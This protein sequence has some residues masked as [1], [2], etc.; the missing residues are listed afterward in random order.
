MAMLETYFPTGIVTGN[1]FCNR[2]K[3]REYL[4]RR[5]EQNA[6]IVL[7][8]P[9][10]YGKSSLVAQFT[11]DQN[12]PF[13]SVD[14]LP[15]TS[16][17]YVKNAI[18]DGVTQ[19]LDAI[20]PRLKNSKQKLLS[21][22]SRMNPVIELSAFG[23]KI[24]LNPDEK[25]HA[26]TIM[27]LLMSL[28]EAAKSLNQRLIFVIDEFQQIATLE[29]SHS[30]EASIRHAVERSK[31]V[32][33]IFAG[34]N[35]TLLE[36][37]FKNKDRPLYH[38]CDEMKLHRI[39]ADNYYPFIKKAAIKRWGNP[40]CDAS[41]EGIIFLTERHPYYF[42]RLCRML[43]DHESPP[44]IDLVE[45]T[46]SQYVEAQKIDWASEMISRLT[47]NQKTILANLA[48]SSEKELRGKDFSNKLEMASS[49]IQRTVTGLLRKDFAYR[50]QDGFYHVL[51]PVI[52]T[53]LAEDKYFD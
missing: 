46:W 15:A 41:I 1:A 21:F 19:L 22:F 30:L 29:E 24:K 40:I 52:K 49:S 8:S 47:V 11:L 9:R 38:L 37:M 5:F 7:M 53:I 16:S 33:Y 31:H 3:E 32:F 51:N 20:M 26:E 12:T 48:R 36:E 6:H 35:R 50:D 17:K 4:K 13:A 43:W 18:V 2:E 34:S 28:D 23:Q 44:N 14:L 45:S 25:T 10:R 27:K 42:N 39:A